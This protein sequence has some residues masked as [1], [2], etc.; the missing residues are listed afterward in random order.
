MKKPNVIHV[1]ANGKHV[2]SIEGHVIPSDNPV[3][4][5]ILETSLTKKGEDEV[6]KKLA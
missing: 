6:L 3:Y 2:K 5:I 1:L 4:R